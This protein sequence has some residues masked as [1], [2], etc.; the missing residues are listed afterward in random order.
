MAIPLKYNLRNLTV[1]KM[2]T[3]ATAGGIALV[4]VVTL[5]LLSLIVGLQKMLAAT[6]GEHNLVVMRKGAT[7][8]GSSSVTREAVQALRY[9]PGIA[10]TPDGEPFVSP[11]LII[12]PFGQPKGGG[13]ENMLVRGV[14]PMAFQVHAQVRLV[15]G[16]M[17]QPSLGE[18]IVGLSASHRYQ[19]A[20]LGETL[21]FGRR[22]WKVVGIF[23]AEGSAFESEVWVDVEDLF[24]DA[25]RSSYS[26]VRLTLAPEA[27]RDAFIRRL[28]EDPRISLEATPEVDYY[29][30]QAES[31]NT[32]YVLTSILALI[33]GTGAVFG[34]MN[35]MFAAVTHRT[36]EIGTLRALGF[37]RATVLSAFMRESLCLALVGYLG[38]VALGA[39]AIFVVNSLIHGV[40]F[41]LASF[42][43]AV[44]TLRLSPTILFAA[45]LLAV[46]MGLLGGF[47]PARRAARLGVIEALRR[48]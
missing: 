13:R 37:S 48:A 16:R 19:G 44:V 36:A 29:S 26:G 8:D 11:E 41:N 12:Q 40:A 14:S 43:T 46:T 31:A 33:M 4:V 2:T 27:D 34:A 28:A 18:A 35:T 20:G 9:L 23:N 47:L 3:L 25:N 45:L 6:G 7:N 5:L 32:L 21:S 10:R 39:G 30:E 24:T 15:A 17:L 38:G 1:R 22:S 42:S